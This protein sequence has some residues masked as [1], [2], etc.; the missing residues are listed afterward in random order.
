M[1]KYKQV[2]YQSAGVNQY[3]WKCVVGSPNH[4]V[5]PMHAELGKRSDKGELFTWDNPPIVDSKGDRKNPGQDFGCRCVA[6]PVVTF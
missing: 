1:T 2:R 5:R 4:P 6:I 3:K